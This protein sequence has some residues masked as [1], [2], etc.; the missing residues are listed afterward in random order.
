LP[1]SPEGD[2]NYFNPKET[3]PPSSPTF[4]LQD[5]CG[6]L[7]RI[8][9]PI[10]ASATLTETDNGLKRVDQ[11][12][13]AVDPTNPSLIYAS[14]AGASQIMISH[15]GGASWQPNT[16]LTNLITHNGAFP[17]TSQL[18]YPLQ[19][20]FPFGQVGQPST[21]AIDPSSD[22]II[23]GTRTAGILISLD[24]G[25][26]WQQVPGSEQIPRAAGFFFDDR[27]GAIY[28][29]SSGRGLWQINI[30]GRTGNR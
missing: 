3:G 16:A 14:D 7:F 20:I 26:D 4:Y 10:D 17:Y 21:I 19:E 5:C 28:V 27:T 9:G 8:S 18:G 1:F 22:T 25:T 30:P 24:N 29:G 13:F 15:D 12:A 2:A 11:G 23:V 6:R